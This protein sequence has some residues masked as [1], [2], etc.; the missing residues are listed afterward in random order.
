MRRVAG[1]RSRASREAGEGPPA[2]RTAVQ[3][4]APTAPSP[5]SHGSRPGPAGRRP[6]SSGG[7]P[8]AAH[9]GT[10]PPP[11]AVRQTRSPSRQP[12]DPPHRSGARCTSG[13]GKPAS[14]NISRAL[15][16]IGERTPSSHQ[17][18]AAMPASAT[19]PRG[20]RA[21]VGQRVASRARTR[22]RAASAPVASSTCATTG[23]RG[24][25]RPPRRGAGRGGVRR[26]VKYEGQDGRAPSPTRRPASRPSSTWATQVVPARLGRPGRP[27]RV[28]VASGPHDAGIRRHPRHPRRR[29]QQNTPPRPE[30][31]GTRRLLR[32]GRLALPRLRSGR[33]GS[34]W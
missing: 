10:P 28:P 3:V 1:S 23:L 16:S 29:V 22:D 13:S 14:T 15:V 25:G 17:A 32:A 21:S 19:A 9:P 20:R 5:A 11:A 34:W 31:G 12:L 18:S 7:D 24:A 6:H 8:R 30:V 26:L 2:P 33:R 27:G 4:L